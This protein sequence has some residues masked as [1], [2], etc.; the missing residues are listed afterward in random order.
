M[1][2]QKQGYL[3]D[4]EN[5]AL[6]EQAPKPCRLCQLYQ[7]KRSVILHKP[8]Q[9]CGA[10]NIATSNDVVLSGMMIRLATLGNCPEH[11]PFAES[12]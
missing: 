3:A 8:V 5:A 4:D 12:P 9:A 1:E 2:D 10:I 7:V 11:Q 6:R